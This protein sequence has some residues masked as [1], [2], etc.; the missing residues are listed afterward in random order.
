[1]ST[2][3]HTS[4]PARQ[5]HLSPAYVSAIHQSPERPTVFPERHSVSP[6]YQSP[7]HHTAS[8]VVPVSVT[9]VFSSSSPSRHRSSL[10]P[11]TAAAMQE[12]PASCPIIPGRKTT[13]EINKGKSG[14]GLSIIGGSDTLL[15]CV[16][17]RFCAYLMACL[18]WC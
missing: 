2:D 10:T 1:M 15:V 5:P 9:P 6:V 4:S 13:I 7:S 8:S 14:L 18:I 12:D 11:A 3:V 16:V 17:L